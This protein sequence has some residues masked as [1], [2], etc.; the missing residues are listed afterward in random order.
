M[1]VQPCTRRSNLIA[2]SVSQLAYA[3]TSWSEVKSVCRLLPRAMT[4]TGIPAGQNLRRLGTRVTPQIHRTT[5]CSVNPMTTYRGVLPN[6]SSAKPANRRQL[7]L[8]L[9]SDPRILFVHGRGELGMFLR[10][11]RLHRP[12]MA[13]H[14]Q[15]HSIRK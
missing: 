8:A 4:C 3:E 13:G 1:N 6:P 15:P 11:S 10:R 14:F 7:T 5:S 2:P 12:G 9:Y